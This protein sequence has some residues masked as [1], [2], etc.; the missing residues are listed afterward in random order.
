MI[1]DILKK[2]Y[3]KYL[4]GLDIYES[5]TSLIL[6]RIVIKDDARDS[7]VGSSIMSELIHY[8]DSN[9]LIVALSP[10][11]DF[12]GSKT[13]LIKF[14]KRFGFKPNKGS[15][16]DYEFKETMIRYPSINENQK[17]LIKRLVTEHFKTKKVKTT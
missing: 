15:N 14:Y 10:S 17:T 9:E 7:G 11:T 5:P 2:K 13:R 16:K 4:K 6:S 12:G 1:E 3:D 8:A